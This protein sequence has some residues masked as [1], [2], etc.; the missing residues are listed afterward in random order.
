MV[1]IREGRFRSLP[2]DLP[3][4]TLFELIKRYWLEVQK[5]ELRWRFY[6]LKADFKMDL[7]ETTGKNGQHVIL[8]IS[9]FL[10]LTSIV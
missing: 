1:H 5:R 9:N 4:Y 8:L 3:I 7:T 10:Y 2:F 6:W